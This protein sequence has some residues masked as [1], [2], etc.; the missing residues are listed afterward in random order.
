MTSESII[1][2]QAVRRGVPDTLAKL[3]VAQSK[4]ET[5]NYKHRFFKIGNNAFGYSADKNSKWQIKPGSK[6]DNGI[7]IAQYSKVEDSVNE[8]VDWIKRRQREGRFPKDLSE[9]KTPSQYGTMLFKA[10]YGGT[11]AKQYSDG[12]SVYFKSVLKQIGS[13]TGTVAVFIFIAIA[14]L[15]LTN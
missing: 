12:S 5:G 13:N 3:I 1:Y 2:N 10:N 8:L 15:L 14:I 9:I 11:S 7:P 4:L 6:A